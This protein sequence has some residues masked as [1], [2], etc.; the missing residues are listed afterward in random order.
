[1]LLKPH[2]RLYQPLS[3]TTSYSA[4]FSAGKIG[5]QWGNFSTSFSKKLERRVKLN[6]SSRKQEHHCCQ[7]LKSPNT[8]GHFPWF[9]MWCRMFAVLFL[10]NVSPNNNSNSSYDSNRVIITMIETMGYIHIIF[11]ILTQLC[12]VPFIQFYRW[13]NWNTKQAICS[14]SC[15]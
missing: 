11:Q 15:S 7:M 2:P 14:R 5:F 8:R 6:C 13:G 9:C 4:Y 1:M 3:Q 10:L 12:K